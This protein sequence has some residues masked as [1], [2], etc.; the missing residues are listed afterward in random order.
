MYGNHISKRS[1]QF[2]FQTWLLFQMGHCGVHV[3]AAE[4]E[5]KCACLIGDF[6]A[7]IRHNFM[8]LHQCE[9]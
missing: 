1:E 3:D 4:C 2:K 9:G 6:Q 8:L 7:A 5:M